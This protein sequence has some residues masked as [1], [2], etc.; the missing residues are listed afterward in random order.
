MQHCD[1][2][3]CTA[4]SYQRNTKIVTQR[5][6]L[7]HQENGPF[8]QGQCQCDLAILEMERRHL[9]QQIGFVQLRLQ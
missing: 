4:G 6:L 9:L 7:R 8:D 1:A 2:F 3:L 5:C